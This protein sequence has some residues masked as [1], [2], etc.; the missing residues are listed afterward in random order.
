MLHLHRSERADAL[1]PPLAAVLADPPDDPFTPDVVAVPTRGVERWLAQRLSHHLGAGPDGEPGVCANVTFAAP[2]RLVGDVLA[3]AA[4]RDA[5]DDPWQAERLT[6][7]LLEVID[8]VLG[9]SWAAPLARYLGGDEDEVRRGRRLGLARHVARLFAAYASQRPA[10]TDAWARGLDED[11]AGAP[12]PADLAWQPVLWRRLRDRVG[13][14]SPGEHLAEALAALQA[15]PD[16]VDL[17]AR[18]SVFG[19]TRLP[20][21]QLRVLTTLA[22]HRDVH[23]WL[24]H[25]SPVLWDQIAAA[26][27]APSRRRRD[28]AALAGHPMLASMARDATELQRRLGA[29]ATS[30]GP[31]TG[32][33][34]D[35]AE[36]VPPAVTHHPAPAPAATLLGA[37]QQRLR[38]DDPSAARQALAPGDRTVQVHACHGRTRQVEVLR[39]VLA[40]L[41]A[42]DPTLEPR[43]VIVMSPDIESVAP[44]VT[45]TFG[46]VAEEAEHHGKVHPGQ[47]LRVRLADR[48]PGRIN[49]VLGV[50]SSLLTLADGRVTASEVLDLAA[51][52]PVR[53]RFRLDGDDLDRIRDWSVAAGVHWGEDLGRRARF[54]LPELRQGTW[55]V[56][57]DRILLGAAMAEE[58]HRYVG[59]ALPMDD[60]DSTDIDLAGRLTELLDRLTDVLDTLDGVRPLAVWL[61]ALDRAVTLLTDTTPTDAW[62]VVQARRVL[63]GV[64]AGGQHHADVPLRL[65]DVRALL[66]DRLAGRPTRTG[67]RTGALTMCS[68]EPMRAVPHRVVCLLGVDDGA[69]PRGTSADGD[70]VLLR[71]PLLGERDRRSEDRQLFLDAVTAAGEHLVV[72]YTGADE[73]TGATRPPAVPV[74]ELL[75]ALD[76][77]AATVDGRPVRDHVLVRHP[78]QVVD[79]RNFAAGAL[80]RPGPFSFDAV[81]H[82]AAQA[83]RGPRTGTT[84]FLTEPLPALDAPL[85]VDLDDLVAMLEHPVKWFLRRRLQLSLAGDVAEVEDR[86]PLALD[87]LATW[88]IG[89]RLL[90]ARLAGVDQR[91]AVNAEWRRGEVPPRELGRTT[92]LDVDTR[93]AP[94]ADAARRFAVG[95]ATA[96]DATVRLPA[97]L[98]MTGT[99]PGVH[100]TTVVRTVFSRLAPKHRLRAWV[101]V[102]A[103]AAAHPGRDWQAA[104]IGRPR[105][106]RPGAVVSRLTA[107]PQAEAREL[108]DQLVHL[109]SLAAREPLPMPVPVSCAYA[110]SRYGGDSEAMALENATREWNGGFD[111]TDEHHVLCWGDG[112]SLT[113]VF[114][115][116][117]AAEQA[118]WPQ[119]RTRLGVLARRVWE[120]LLAHE[121][122]ELP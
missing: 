66:A 89:D 109:R 26:G 29:T 25:P 18:L 11:G 62:Q 40:G 3:A 111:R 75:D 83:G 68:L 87:P 91:Q 30:T 79:E 2:H 76:A 24:P 84:A 61:D 44:L 51:T 67:F 107:P 42:D 99:V 8:D 103:L 46:L 21:D 1:V 63:A 90:A 13:V 15:S 122:T 17:P 49:P 6:W 120:P 81:A 31:G 73:R 95:P 28:Q 86:L 48:S 116:A 101:Q 50:L 35:A 96:V 53:R 93:V 94:I 108:L 70:N 41:F 88:Q 7:P 98:D 16:A 113:D 65:P 43:D 92:L 106:N 59:P 60:V 78:L 33:G 82:R 38:D 97:G 10:L 9:E 105:H 20:E 56:A 5:D 104:T 4:H 74:G 110:T 64:R 114:G 47:T 115:T 23:L 52:E 39:E 102:L 77:A 57:L 71:D 80:G 119:D 54:G 55:D 12:V 118:W 121:E 85:G 69:F 45:A 19:P 72:L 36:T 112:A 37:L 58:D 14:P 117:T 22:A 100:E 34:A 32:P 27:P